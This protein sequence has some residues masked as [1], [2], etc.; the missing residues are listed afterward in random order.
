MSVRIP[1]TRKLSSEQYVNST[2]KSAYLKL[3]K[4]TLV[5]SD[6]LNDYLCI[7]LKRMSEAAGFKSAFCIGTFFTNDFI[8]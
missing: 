7:K 4:K 1:G 8:T 5:F 6:S 3:E 2:M